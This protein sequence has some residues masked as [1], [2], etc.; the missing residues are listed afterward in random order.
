MNEASPENNLSPQPAQSPPADDLE[1]KI[2]ESWLGSLLRPV[3][4]IVLVLCI[5]AALSIFLRQYAPGL[6]AGARW[7]MLALG[8][9]AAVVGVVT[10]TWLAHPNQRLRRNAGSRFAESLLL[11]FVARLVL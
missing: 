3:L 1:P 6:G 5:H 8:L 11:L 4:V 2:D 9:I 10:T 7:A